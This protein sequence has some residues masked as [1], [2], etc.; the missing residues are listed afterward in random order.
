[1]R[2]VREFFKKVND[3]QE[4]WQ[5]IIVRKSS[6]REGIVRFFPSCQY[7]S[8]NKSSFYSHFCTSLIFFNLWKLL[9]PEIIWLSFFLFPL[10]GERYDFINGTFLRFTTQMLFGLTNLNNLHRQMCTK[11]HMI[12]H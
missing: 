11:I 9:S 3:F 10:I 5:I 7:M 4:N 12:S 6:K 2:R 8:E 1:M